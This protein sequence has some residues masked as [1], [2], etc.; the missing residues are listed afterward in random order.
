MQEFGSL[1]SRVGVDLTIFRFDLGTFAVQH[2]Y[3][4]LDVLFF[5]GIED[6]IEHQ[7]LK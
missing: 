2:D 7:A 6:E 4:I 1:L 3:E 5:A